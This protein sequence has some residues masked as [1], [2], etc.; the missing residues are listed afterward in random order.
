MKRE[1]VRLYGAIMSGWLVLLGGSAFTDLL[2]QAV[3]GLLVL[4]TAAVKVAVDEYT[5]SKVTPVDQG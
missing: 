1:P 3:T 2:P 4:G 5:R